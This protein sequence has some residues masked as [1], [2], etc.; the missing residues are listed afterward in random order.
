MKS[1]TENLS[2]MLKEQ[3]IIPHI[4]LTAFKFR[5]KATSYIKSLKL[6][7]TIDQLIILRILSFTPS[8]S[9]NELAEILSKDKS[10]LSR[11][12]DSL[13]KKGYILREAGLKSKRVV[14]KNTI[15]AEGEKTVKKLMNIAQTLHSR[16][17]K[18]ISQQELSTLK[19][20]LQKIR[21]NLNSE[22]I[23]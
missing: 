22:G 13:E 18:G 7:L 9:Q 16:A 20:L 21:D 10:N 14:K 3:F 5:T 4:S 15:T 8:I 23:T 12:M 6:D 11:M 2:E 1:L 19:E 17:L